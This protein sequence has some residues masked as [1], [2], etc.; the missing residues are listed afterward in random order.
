M[1]ESH[2][3]T[4]IMVSLSALVTL[5]A[6]SMTLVGREEDVCFAEIRVSMNPDVCARTWMKL[7]ELVV[8]HIDVNGEQG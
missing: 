6:I 8:N 1:F 2:S 5:T 4:F 3:F 7:R